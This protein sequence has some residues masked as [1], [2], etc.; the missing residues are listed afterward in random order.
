MAGSDAV[1]PFLFQQL[2]K[3]LIAK[4]TGRGLQAEVLASG[5]SRDIVIADVQLQ[6]MPV[7]QLGDEL[8]VSVGFRSAQLV[9]EMDNRKDDT[10]FLPQL[11]H[12]SQESY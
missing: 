3:I 7:G 10:E 9:I 12:D 4:L 5:V 2:P 6:I 11:E 1:Q 8:F